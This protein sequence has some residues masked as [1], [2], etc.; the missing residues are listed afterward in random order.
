MR[1]M[2]P[3]LAVC[4]LLA[5]AFLTSGCAVTGG[6]TSKVEA[7]QSSPVNIRLPEMKAPAQ[8]SA[9][10]VVPP[11]VDEGEPAE[12]EAIEEEAPAVEPAPTVQ[13]TPSQQPQSTPVAPDQP[14]VPPTV[15]QDNTTCPT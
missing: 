14:I 8:Q 10:V 12:E 4:A 6:G 5:A 1:R 15:P 2:I 7:V 9:P 3:F 13:T 11:P